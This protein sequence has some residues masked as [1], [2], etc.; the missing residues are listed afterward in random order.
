MQCINSPLPNIP[1]KKNISYALLFHY[2]SLTRLNWNKILSLAPWEVFCCWEVGQQQGTWDNEEDWRELYHNAL[3]FSFA[4]CV[5]LLPVIYWKRVLRK[6]LMIT[7]RVIM[8]VVLNFNKYFILGCIRI[9][10]TIQTVPPAHPC[11]RRE[12]QI[13]K[14]L[15]LWRPGLPEME[16]K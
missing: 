3:C 7:G 5:Y 12:S 8:T 16:Q 6:L 4:A 14:R 9:P 10:M 11:V 13:M 15:L 2:L 1:T